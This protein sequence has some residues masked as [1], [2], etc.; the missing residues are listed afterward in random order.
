MKR[1]FSLFAL[2]ILSA[3]SNSL[4]ANNKKDKKGSKDH[5]LV[6]RYKNSRIVGYNY[7]DFDQYDLVTGPKKNPDKTP[8]R[9]LEGEIT[10]IIYETADNSESLLKVFR[11]FEIAFQK[12]GVKKLYSCANDGCGKR[13]PSEVFGNKSVSGRY[14]GADP[15]NM[16]GSINYHLWN[17]K[18]KK[19]GKD[20]YVNL[21]ANTYNFGQ[22]PINI[23]LDVV[24][25]AEMETDLVTLDP[26]FI[27]NELA[28]SG[29]VVLSGVEF[30]TDKD[31]LKSTS[32]DALK[33]IAEY[34]KNNL[35][36][37]VYIVGHTDNRGQ[38]N[39]NKD[40]SERRARSIVKLLI[41]QYQ[42]DAARLV[43]IGVADVSPITHNGEADSRAKNRRVEMVL[44]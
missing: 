7:T 25:V 11:N 16:G 20:I 17:G 33:V 22:Y 23:V 27:K 21:I 31:T 8:T 9:S 19:D 5:P 2:L 4:L 29:R 43:A 32:A 28:T 15:W 14:L 1:V 13:M 44:R 37:K 18:L 35:A 6:Q 41:S 42:I 39:Y 24:E 3:S 26:Q 10:T 40:L 34:L 38:Y 30:D 36:A 12:A